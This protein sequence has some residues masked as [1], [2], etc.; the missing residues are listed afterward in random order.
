M[1]LLDEA[2]LNTQSDCFTD[3][4]LSNGIRSLTVPN[5]VLET[6]IT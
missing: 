1:R 4:V 6:S 5:P 3:E 2:A